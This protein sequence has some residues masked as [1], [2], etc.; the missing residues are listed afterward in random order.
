MESPADGAELR[1]V[2][3]QACRLDGVV[4]GDIDGER[5]DDDGEVEHEC[6]D[7]AGQRSSVI[8]RSMEYIYRYVSN[9]PWRK[10]VRQGISPLD[11]GVLYVARFDANGAGT[12][13][14]LVAARRTV[15]TNR[16]GDK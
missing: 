12:W 7:D 3:G 5:D 14:P 10:S 13:L 2:R 8:R 1:Q 16:C 6:G 9:Q 11:D 15:G 4:E